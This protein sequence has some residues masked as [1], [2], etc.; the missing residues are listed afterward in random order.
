M[1][2]GYSPD[3]VAKLSSISCMVLFN[4][5]KNWVYEDSSKNYNALISEER[6][7]A[8]V[9]H[10]HYEPEMKILHNLNERLSY[11]NLFTCHLGM[12][13]E[14]TIDQLSKDYDLPAMS[15]LF[16]YASIEKKMS[17]ASDYAEIFARLATEQLG[18]EITKP[19]FA[20]SDDETDTLAF[21]T[22]VDH[23]TE[24]NDLPV[25]CFSARGLKLALPNFI[26]ILQ[27]ELTH[28]VV[29]CMGK[30]ETEWRPGEIQPY[31]AYYED[32]MLTFA[33]AQNKDVSS[34]FF[35]DLYDEDKEEQLCNIVG[36]MAGRY[37]DRFCPSSQIAH[38]PALKIQS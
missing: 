33:K 6:G 19:Y 9:D 15:S 30:A 10:V 18:I 23:E 5:F 36:L 16:A 27:H 35:P 32:I 4:Y 37:I 26:G 11:S 28:H 12:I 13:A 31:H 17:F 14:D 7:R 3:A 25:V 29:D 38:Q 2:V 20:Y 34:G 24:G 21:Y 22:R 8:I 1:T